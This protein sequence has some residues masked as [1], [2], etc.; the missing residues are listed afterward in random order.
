M[1]FGDWISPINGWTSV[2]MVGTYLCFFQLLKQSKRPLRF[3]WAYWMI[4][5]VGVLYWIVISMYRHGGL[6]LPLSIGALLGL[7]ALRAGFFT[8]AVWAWRRFSTQ[9]SLIIFGATV[10]TLSDWL[11]HYF[12]LEGFPWYT[13]VYGLASQLFMVQTAQWWGAHGIN[14]MFH[15]WVLACVHVGFLPLD[16]STRKVKKAAVGIGSCLLLWIGVGVFL[17]SQ[18]VPTKEPSLR[19]GVIQGNIK[20]AMKWD[21]ASKRAILDKYQAMTHQ[22][23]A[24]QT[25]P[26]DLI[27]WPEA[28]LPSR[29]Q[30]NDQTIV[31]LAN[32]QLQSPLLVGTARKAVKE[33]QTVFFNSAVVMQPDYHLTYGYD[34]IRLVPFGEFFPTFGI[35]ALQKWFSGIA[36]SFAPG[37]TWPVATIG[38]EKLGVS[39][40][41]EILFGDHLRPFFQQ[42]AT[43]I[44]NITN[45]AWFEKSSGPYQHARFP[46]VRSIEYR[47][48]IIRVANTGITALYRAD[49]SMHH[50]TQLFTPSAQVYKVAPNDHRTLYQMLPWLIYVWMVAALMFS[51]YVKKTDPS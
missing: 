44:V 46:Q 21:R 17:Q 8:L 41:Y 5:N 11:L 47:K 35:A 15:A 28:A 22:L 48:P 45:D 33:N 12:P 7:S 43:F 18:W 19:A 36:G 9:K 42:G 25:Q 49:G 27:I 26:L 10:F 50:A 6:S 31:Q 16:I 29:I 2:C 1:A 24:A 4:I 40:C 51:V 23:Q 14:W 34:K 38:T 39:I 32:L 3:A 13:P 37:T 30:Y 20:Q